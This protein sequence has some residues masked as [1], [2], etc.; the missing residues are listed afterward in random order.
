MSVSSSRKHDGVAYRD[1]VT[2]HTN[3]ESRLEIL[4]GT[5]SEFAVTAL[6]RDGCVL[7][8]CEVTQRILQRAGARPHLT[9][10]E[11]GIF[12]RNGARFYVDA[13][14]HPEY[15]APETANP[16]DAVCYSLAGDRLVARF[17]RE[18]SCEEPR[19]ASL[20]V[21]KGNIDYACSTTWGSHENYLHRRS[22]DEV[23]SALVSHLV[24]RIVFTGSG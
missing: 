5:E 9:G 12:L 19:I 3:R 17:A 14:H 1:P 2:L 4:F 8:V 10:A 6:D 18:V 20:V 7:P 11:S 16:W 24:S 21:R 15:A 23:R 22:P 13:G